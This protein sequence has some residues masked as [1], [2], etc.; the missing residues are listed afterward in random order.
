MQRVVA[1]IHNSSS[2]IQCVATNYTSKPLRC[3]PLFFLLALTLLPSH[4]YAQD[5][6]SGLIAH[7]K[8]DEGSGTTAADLSGN[9]NTG[10]LIN[11]TTWTLAPLDGGEGEDWGSF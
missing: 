3:I 8:F 5:I 1:I 11:G 9:N 4:V 6:T 7:W 10:T 2:M